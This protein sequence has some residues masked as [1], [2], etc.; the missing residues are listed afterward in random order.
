MAGLGAKLFT[1]FSKLTAAQ[2]NGYLMDQSIMRFASAAVRD[3][4][5]GGV[6]EPTLAEGMHCYLDDTNEM[7]SYNGSAWVSVTSGLVYITSATATTGTTLAIANAFSSTYENYRIVLS[8]VRLTSPAFAVFQFTGT[9]TNYLYGRLEVPYNTATGLGRGGSGAGTVSSW[10]LMVGDTTSNGSSFDIFSPNLPRQ[11]SYT[12]ASPDP[13][14]GGSFGVQ[15]AG[16]IQT[17]TT[18]FTGLTITTGAT[19]TNMNCTI[20]GYRKG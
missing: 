11:T 14:T 19:I 8:D 4:A 1:A 20:Y 15:W 16:G 17:S 7:Q 12:G 9:N 18:Q 3:A 6:G 13:R 5:F 2:V 10:D